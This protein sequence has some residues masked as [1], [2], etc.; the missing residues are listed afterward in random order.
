M[1]DHHRL[2]IPDPRSPI[3]AMTRF[4]PGFLWGAATAAYQIE[5]AVTEDGR[6]AS[7]WDAY[8]RV[9]G[10]IEGGDTGEIAAGSYER[11]RED[12][13][14]MA[15]LGLR[16]YRF[17]TGWSRIMPDRSTSVGSISTTRWSTR[18]WPPGS[19]RSSRSTTGTCHRRC[20]SA[21]AGAA[22]RRWSASSNT[23]TW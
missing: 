13:A 15:E 7:I 9:P 14:L 22:A 12:V 18:C 20:R 11:W 19:R 16:G 4:P 6:G 21:G 23:P 8:C 3:P 10:A 17:S 5:G 1:I 2:P